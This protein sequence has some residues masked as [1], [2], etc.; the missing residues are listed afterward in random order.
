L[1]ITYYFITVQARFRH[2]LEPIIT[3]L[4]VFLFQSATLRRKS[5]D[6]VPE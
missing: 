5:P 4:A 6:A 1:P 2:T 3:I